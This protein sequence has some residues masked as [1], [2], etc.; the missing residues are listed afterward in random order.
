MNET[1]TELPNGI[2][3]LN[4]TPFFTANV[5]LAI[6]FAIFL[7]VHVVLTIRYWRYYGYALGMLSGLLLE[8]LGCVAKVKLSHNRADKSSYIM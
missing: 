4:F 8:L 6:L 7:S 2:G 5:I 3:A 1:N